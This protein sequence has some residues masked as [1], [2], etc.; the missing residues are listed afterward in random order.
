MASTPLEKVLGLGLVAAVAFGAL[1]LLLRTGERRSRALGAMGYPPSRFPARHLTQVGPLAALALT[2]AR[3]ALLHAQLPTH[4]DLAPWL[5]AFLAELRQLMEMAYRVQVITEVYGPPAHLE[6]I[7]TEVQGLEQQIA[8]D[9]AQHLLT[10]E[11]NAQQE[12]LDDR[13][14]TLHLCGQE[15]R[16]AISSPS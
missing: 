1:W 12:L 13:L 16:R 8:Q 11:G 6:R 5:A 7:V 4:S 3:L 10:H 2:E 15:L 14:A 9:V